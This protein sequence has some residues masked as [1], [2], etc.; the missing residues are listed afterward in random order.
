MAI[1]HKRTHARP[2]FEIREIY[3]GLRVFYGAHNRPSEQLIQETMYRFRNK[4]TVHDNIRYDSTHPITR[5][6]DNVQTRGVN[7]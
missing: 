3:R 2:T 5:R 4:V 1:Y 6:T 7:N